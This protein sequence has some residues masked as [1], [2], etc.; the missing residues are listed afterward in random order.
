M[1]VVFEIGPSLQT[2]FA[3]KVAC[4]FGRCKNNLKRAHGLNPWGKGSLLLSPRLYAEAEPFLETQPP[5]TQQSGWRVWFLPCGLRYCGIQWPRRAGISRAEK[6]GGLNS[7]GVSECRGRAVPAAACPMLSSWFTPR[8]RGWLVQPPG[9]R[10][11][12]LCYLAV[13][14][15]SLPPRES[16]TVSSLL[17]LPNLFKKTRSDCCS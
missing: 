6:S 8:V 9:S 13:S 4:K 3:A 11:S 7:S 2:N 1:S 15:T 10:P 17:P 5:L 12:P 14:F 16:D